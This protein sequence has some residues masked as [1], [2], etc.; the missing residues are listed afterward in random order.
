MSQEIRLKVGSHEL[1]FEKFPR[2]PKGAVRVAVGATGAWTE[3]NWRRDAD[4]IWL[5]FSDRVIGFDLQV[6]RDE[7][8]RRQLRT[9]E[10]E[11]SMP[12]TFRE[13]R[14]FRDGED[15]A[16][17]A[18]GGKKKG[19]RVKAQMP[20]KIVRVLVEKGQSVEKD[21]PLLVMEAM[22]MENEIRA[23]AAG[24]VANVKVA[25]GQAVETGAELLS[26]E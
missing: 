7:E 18:D 20:G 16:K 25:P 19:L 5:E 2:G 10:R 24:V 14:V 17:G 11:R 15:K 12:A 9:R 8:G 1:R 3:V 4:G 23:T 6:E 13:L 26:L 22:K 21:Q